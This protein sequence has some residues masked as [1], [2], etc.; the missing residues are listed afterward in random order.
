MLVSTKFSPPRI[1]ASS[2]QRRKLLDDLQQLEHCKL[3]LIV[4]SPGFGKTTLMVQWRQAMIETGAEVAW[5]SLSVEDRLL[6]TFYAYLHSALLRLGLPLEECAQLD[7]SDESIDEVMTLIVDGAASLD[8]ELFL[9][10]DDYQHV[11]DPRSHR[12]MQKLLDYSPTNL[13]LLLSSRVALP[14]SLGRLRVAGQLIEMDCSTLPFDLDETRSFFE[15][16]LAALKLNEEELHLIQGLSG[17]WP[18]SLQ[19]ILIMLKNRPGAREQLSDL[20]RKSDDLQAYLSEDVMTHLPAELTEFMESLSI[21]RRFNAALATA[22]TDNSQAFDFLKRLETEN[23]LTFRVDTDDSHSW[24]RF[25][26]LFGDFLLERL[27]RR[28]TEAVAE[29]HRRAARWLAKHNHLAEATRHAIQSG[30]FELAVEI[31]EHVASNTSE[32]DYLRPLMRLL[33]R[34]PQDVLFMRPDLLC[35][36]CIAYTLLGQPA[37]AEACLEQL[38][39]RS[40]QQNA[41]ITHHLPLMRAAIELQNDRTEQVV[42]LLA[43]YRPSPDDHTLVRYVPLT[44]MAF[45]YAAAGKPAE[46][47]RYL[48]AHPVAEA[49]RDNEIAL[50]AENSRLLCCLFE[51]KVREVAQVSSELLERAISKHGHRS[52]SAKLCAATVAEV[53]RELNRIEEAREVLANRTDVMQ[54]AMPSIMLRAT[55]CRARLDLLQESPAAALRFLE[56]QERHFRRIGQDRGYAYTLAEQVR[57]LL[58]GKDSDQVSS[59]LEKLETLAQQHRDASGFLAEIPILAALSSARNW[60]ATGE[61]NQ[62]LKALAKV[63]DHARQYSRGQLEVIA[64]LL[65][66][67]AHDHLQQTDAADTALTAALKLGMKLGLV[68]TFIDEGEVLRELMLRFNDRLCADDPVAAYLA[69]LLSHFPSV[70]TPPHSDV[71][72]HADARPVLTPREVAILQLISQAMPNKRIALALNISPETVKW[73]LKNINAKLGVSSRYDAMTWARKHKLIN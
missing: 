68:R 42:E 70:D 17:G 58:L 15:Q 59:R 19:L 29:L 47:A 48:D 72:A 36:Y 56:R 43:D 52:S 16:N 32:I 60:L 6:P 31:I 35:L 51:G 65:Q 64:R 18:A 63:I 11:M 3:G 50:L 9:L 71:D 30:D 23:I 66:A 46:A 39:R 25:H 28:G 33:D 8:K 40:A 4:G 20:G 34:L 24:Y 12:L 26:P 57:I 5:L 7:A 38:Q 13:H 2:V 73:N 22:I 61:A 10:I 14:L 62:A 27:A 49:D 54:W 41:G 37:K 44:L 53:Y 45:A 67:I 21:C 69:D 55:I 1:G